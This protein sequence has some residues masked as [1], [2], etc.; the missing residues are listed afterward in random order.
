MVAWRFLTLKMDVICS[1]ETSVHI[2]ST[3]RCI[4][5]DDNISN[6]RS[7]NLI[8]HCCSCEHVSVNYSFYVLC[9]ELINAIAYDV[10]WCCGVVQLQPADI[11]HEDVLL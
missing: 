5:E 6:Y 8:R 3:R 10:L 7:V 9:Q 2:R 4:A 11:R 1:I